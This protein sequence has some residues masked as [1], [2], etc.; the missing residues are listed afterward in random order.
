MSPLS[1]S[2]TYNPLQAF[3]CF[4]FASTIAALSALPSALT[5][6]KASKPR[7]DAYL[8]VTPRGDSAFLNA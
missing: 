6:R 7:G 5:E 3:V 2:T 1:P 8:A 4:Q